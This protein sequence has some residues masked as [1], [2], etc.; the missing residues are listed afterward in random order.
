MKIAKVMANGMLFYKGKN[1]KLY[2]SKE[3]AL[4]SFKDV[5]NDSRKEYHRRLYGYND[6]TGKSSPLV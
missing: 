6:N 1:G 5:S 2:M 3:A 4:N